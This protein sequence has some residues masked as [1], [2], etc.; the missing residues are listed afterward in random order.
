MKN[1]MIKTVHDLALSFVI[2]TTLLM[3]IVPP[4]GFL[5]GVSDETVYVG[6]ALWAECVYALVCY[7]FRS[8]KAEHEELE[9]ILHSVRLAVPA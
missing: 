1:G 9:N 2:F 5:S 4:Y 6:L 3:L 7:L 8:L